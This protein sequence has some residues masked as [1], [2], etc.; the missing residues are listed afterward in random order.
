MEHIIASAVMS[1]PAKNNILCPD[2]HGVRRGR[3]CEAQ[4]LGYTDEATVEM[5]KGN[6]ENTIVLDL[7][8]AFEKVSHTLLMHKLLRYGIGG[9]LNALIEGFLEDRQQAVVVDG[10][11]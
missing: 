4:L 8:K 10:E 11:T 6:Q 7:T 1:H 9:R 5:E 2:Q 3:L